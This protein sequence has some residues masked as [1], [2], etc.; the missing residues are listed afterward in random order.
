VVKQGTANQVV[1]DYLSAFASKSMKG[2]VWDEVDTAPGN[3]MV[4]LH[5]VRVRPEEGCLPD[6]ITMQTPF[7][8]DV[9]YWNLVPDTRLHVTLHVYNEQQ[10]VAFTT[11]SLRTDQEWAGRPLPVGRF[12]STCHIPGNLLN[13]GTYR[14]LLLVVRNTDRVIYRLEDALQFEVRDFQ[15]RVGTWYGKEPGVV[16]PILPWQTEFL[17]V[18]EGWS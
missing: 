5:R 3:E 18:L 4:R 12:R 6:I 8:I 14:V 7:A 9:E 16:Q 2:R 13:S 17:D 15:E 1:S 10:I 11:G